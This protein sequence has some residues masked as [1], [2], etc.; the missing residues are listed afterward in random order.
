MTPRVK[1][2]IFSAVITFLA[3][4]LMSVTTELTSLTLD[5]VTWSVVVGILLASV[6]AGVKLA[7]EVFV[8]DYAKR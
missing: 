1:E 4:F 2:H 5:T 8:S 3:T 7:F 6:R